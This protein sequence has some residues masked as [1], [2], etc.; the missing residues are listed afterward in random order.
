M[1]DGES[2]DDEIERRSKAM[3]E[4]LAHGT[5]DRRPDAK[6]PLTPEDDEERK[7]GP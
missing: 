6:R 2:E 3:V 5:F 7:A 1:N 4:G